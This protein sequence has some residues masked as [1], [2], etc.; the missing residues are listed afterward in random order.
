MLNP[1]LNYSSA[2]ANA[3]VKAGGTVFI[4]SSNKQYVDNALQQIAADIV[5]VTTIKGQV[6]DYK[7][8]AEESAT[9]ASS[10]A[11]SAATH[12]ANAAASATAA[13]N[14]AQ[15]AADAA[16]TI[17]DNFLEN[18][19]IVEGPLVASD[20]FS[21]IN[22]I[23]T[24]GI[25]TGTFNSN[26]TTQ[27]NPRT[28]YTNTMIIQYAANNQVYQQF[29][30]S[31]NG[32]FVMDG[33][34]ETAVEA[35]EEAD[36]NL[37]NNKLD[38]TGGTVDGNLIITGDMTVQGTTNINDTETLQVKDNFIVTNSDGATLAGYS[39]LIIRTNNTKSYV[40][41][42]DPANGG[43]V[44]LGL[45]IYNE[46]EGT[47]TFDAGEG[48]PIAVRAQDTSWNDA[49]I[50]VWDADTRQL[51]DGGKTVAQLAEA[52]VPGTGISIDDG[53]IKVNTASDADIEALFII[54]FAT[55]SW[56]KIAEISESGNASSIFSVGDEK[57]IELTTGEQVTLVILGFDHDDLSDG[58]GKAGMTIGMKNALAT[59]Y[60][61][62][63]TA[64]NVGGWGDSEMRTDNMQTLYGY[65]PEDLKSVIK[66]VNKLT[67]RYEN[68]GAI[69]TTSDKL[70]LF[71]HVEIMGTNMHSTTGQQSFPGEGEQYEY[72]K[73]APIPSPNNTDEEFSILSD[74]GCFYTTD[75][76]VVYKFTNRFNQSISMNDNWYYN[77]NATKAQ[78]DSAV[79]STSWWLRS[80]TKSSI[81][82]GII[83]SYSTANGHNA[84]YT[85]C[86]SFGF[87]I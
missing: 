64:T 22:G 29:F 16:Q 15:D 3:L 49:R 77:Y 46:T 57:T 67:G 35:L 74:T 6:E 53:V 48:L 23:K 27:V 85:L 60:A 7:D 82:F 69:E 1:M 39:G 28:Y 12:A 84:K 21:A 71:S 81:F 4:D 14:S 54:N 36:T 33:D 52:F 45:G 40:I 68:S 24:T 76:S 2:T 55:A 9:A 38:K 20:E 66:S 10:S 34:L 5:T 59:R 80:P 87:C 19:G 78:G 18:G 83:D 58:S 8:A 79:S 26:T 13:A 70:F 31:K 65:L 63:S 43:T 51:V 62:N 42:Y 56:E 61:M 11:L 32:T 41:I 73:N 25:Y 47:F 86:V 30:P 72:Y 50:A 44:K 17:L 37:A 75:D